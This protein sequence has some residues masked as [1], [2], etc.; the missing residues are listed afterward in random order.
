LAAALTSFW[1]SEEKLGLTKDDWEVV[2]EG[3][4]LSENL[5]LEE[6]KGEFF[7]SIRDVEVDVDGIIY[8]VDGEFSSVKVV[9]AERVIQRSIGGAGKGPGEFQNPISMS[10][11]PKDS[12][13]VLDVN[14]QNNLSIFDPGFEFDRRIPLRGKGVP[15]PDRATEILHVSE[16]GYLARYLSLPLPTRSTLRD[17][18]VQ[19]VSPQGVVSDTLFSYPPTQQDV[20]QRN[21]SIT[22]R[23]IPFARR[24]AVTADEEGNV[25]YAW[26][27]SLG[28]FTYSPG[29]ELRHTVN[30]PFDPIPVTEAD[31]ERALD[32]RSQENRAAVRPK[33]P[34]TKPAFE[35]FLVD[36]QGRYWFGRP[37][38]DPNRTSWWVADPDRK[39]VMTTTLPSVVQLEVVQDGHAYGKTK[40]DKGAPAL[41]RYRIVEQ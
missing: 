25:Y 34:A 8:V 17:N 11:G 7:G 23:S 21:G 5:F 16:G 12:I 9:S 29:G 30:I 14:Y 22:I 15:L 10:I 3:I 38:T 6:S 41:V 37:T 19:R 36:D 27:D 28:V 26:S 35:Q 24:A 4:K 32:G 40:T 39:Q 33:I 20:E 1:L 31:R 13:Y 18:S 2:K